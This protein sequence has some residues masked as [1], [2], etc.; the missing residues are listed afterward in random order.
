MTTNLQRVLGLGGWNVA[1]LSHDGANRRNMLL[2]IQLRWLAV[3]GQ[4][5][6][7][8]LVHYAMRIP[9]PIGLLLIAPAGLAAV[10]LLSAPITARRQGVADREL[11]V[12]LL[13]DVA[14]LTWF[15]MA[16][17][18]ALGLGLFVREDRRRRA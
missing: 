4:A 10:N 11:M 3:A 18:T 1:M 7:I 6:T 8:L 15:G 2:L 17:L 13:A 14:A 5:A 12:A 9:L 16:L